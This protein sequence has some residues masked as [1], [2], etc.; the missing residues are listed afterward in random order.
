MD[1]MRDGWTSPE[2]SAHAPEV[3][4]IMAAYNRSNVLRYA[5]ESVR[6]QTR[7]DWELLVVDDAGTDDTADVVAAFQDAR[8]SFTSL[9][10]N[11]G[12]QSGPNNE[13][14]RR[15]RG[16]YIAF[17]N[18]DDLWLPHHLDT[19]IGEIEASGADLVFPLALRWRRGRFGT[20]P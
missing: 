7:A 4:V 10:G 19:L 5:I 17:L 14:L 8:I 9:P 11:V 2:G 3:S 6:R 12:E 1:A 20:Y 16:R 13:G 15:A 18:Q